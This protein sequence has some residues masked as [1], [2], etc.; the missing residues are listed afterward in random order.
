MLKYIRYLNVHKITVE[1]HIVY[2]FTP[3]A[4]CI[5]QCLPGKHIL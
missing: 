5:W 1:L 3:E 4:A 2:K